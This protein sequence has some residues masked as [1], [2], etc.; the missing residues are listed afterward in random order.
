[1]ARR[2]IGLLMATLVI[3]SLLM[4]RGSEGTLF[5]EE[6][7]GATECYDNVIVEQT[8]STNWHSLA[9]TD[10]TKLTL[11][12]ENLGTPE[13]HLVFTDQGKGIADPSHID[14]AI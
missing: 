8:V 12:I 3:G 4:L 6:V 9:S 7:D 5:S 10:G 2:R 14:T 11:V 1:M 13:I